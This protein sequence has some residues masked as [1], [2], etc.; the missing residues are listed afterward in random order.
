[1]RS[2]ALR[3]GGWFDARL[4]KSACRS[5]LEQDTEPGS[6]GLFQKHLCIE[7]G[8]CRNEWMKLHVSGH[9]VAPYVG[10]PVNQSDIPD[11]SIH[12]GRCYEEGNY[13]PM[14]K[15]FSFEYQFIKERA[16][17]GSWLL[18]SMLFFVLISS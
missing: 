2:A 7:N 12:E 11:K 15:L 17:S 16:H 5:T 8:A 1:M 10:I 14:P 18:L 13:P 4:L 6:V 3:E 9:S